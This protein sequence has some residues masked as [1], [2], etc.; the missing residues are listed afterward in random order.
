MGILK[1]LFLFANFVIL[2]QFA[3]SASDDPKITDMI[4]FDMNIGDDYIGRIEIG[5]FGQI[6]PKTVRNFVELARAPEG[7]GYKGTK[8]HRVIKN[9]M[10]QGG[11]TGGE[12]IYGSKFEDENFILKHVGAGWLSMANSGKD[13]NRS[14]FFITTKATPW[15]DGKHVVFGKVIKGMNVVRQIESTKTDSEDRPEQDV[16]IVSSGI[17]DI[18]SDPAY[19]V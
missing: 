16:I 9:F 8:F 17:L 10:I 12:S 1:L 3:F 15:L 6:V 18:S 14:Q 19:N 13:T 2:L 11:D 4:Y 7:N 5:L